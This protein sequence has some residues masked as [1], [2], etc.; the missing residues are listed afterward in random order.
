[1]RSFVSR[2]RIAQKGQERKKNERTWMVDSNFTAKYARESVARNLVAFGNLCGY[3]ENFGFGWLFRRHSSS[4][5]PFF[6]QLISGAKL[7]HC[8]GRWKSLYV[9][10]SRHCGWRST[11]TLLIA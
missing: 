2:I 8:D 7:G 10:I 1:M 4:A 3:Q 9:S 5:S 11:I 6:S